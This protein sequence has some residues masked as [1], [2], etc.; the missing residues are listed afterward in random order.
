MTSDYRPPLPICLTI[1]CCLSPLP[2]LS[3]E[4]TGAADDI[5]IIQD[6]LR[7]AAA[8]APYTTHGDAQWN[9]SGLDLS[10][11]AT[12]ELAENSGARCKL[13]MHLTLHP[14]AESG[15]TWRVRLVFSYKDSKKKLAVD[16][17]RKQQDD[18]TMAIFRII[19]DKG[20]D[21]PDRE[22]ELRRLELHK[23]IPNANWLFTYHYGLLTVSVDEVELV[24]GYTESGSTDISG[25]RFS[26][27][28]GQV[29]IGSVERQFRRCPLLSHEEQ[30]QLKRAA[31]LT[32]KVELLKSQ[33]RFPA[34]VQALRQARDICQQVYGTSHYDYLEC[35]ANLALLYTESRKFELAQ[36]AYAEALP[37]FERELGSAHPEFA[38]VLNNV[39]YLHSEI[40]SFKTAEEYFVKALAI[41]RDRLGEKHMNTV[42]SLSNLAELYRTTGKFEKA[43]EYHSELTRIGRQVFGDNDPNFAIL[44]NNLAIFYADVGEY[45]NAERTWNEVLNIR[46][47]LLPPGHPYL[48]MTYG[49][50][51]NFYRTIG[52]FAKASEFLNKAEPL[53]KAAL[54]EQHYLYTIVLNNQALLDHETGNLAKSLALNQRVLELRK[55]TLGPE[56][57]SLAATLQALAMLHADMGDFPSA[58]DTCQ[59]SL[60]IATKVSDRSTPTR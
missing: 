49:S 8:R 46:Q 30:E 48:A 21:G 53:V 2:A 26:V 9:A 45:A 42:V 52:E 60:E 39:G 55:Q 11:G 16:V 27:E 7:T 14:S 36:Q 19:G 54:G 1:A 18:R 33:G 3:A 4:Q 58:V 29:T 59:Q 47:R 5:V 57:P 35:L 23:D 6:D 50:M 37:V 44:L 32:K 41:R 17:S 20:D 34:A 56:H 24:S 38:T 40:G 51:G 43:R 31:E 13:G 12:L 25:W 28:R 10:D 22:T 15:E